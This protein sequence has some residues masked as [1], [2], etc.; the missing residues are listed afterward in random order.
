MTYVPSKSASGQSIVKSDGTLNGTPWYETA[1]GAGSNHTKTGPGILIGTSGTISSIVIDSATKGGTDGAGAGG[2]SPNS[3]I[4]AGGGQLWCMPY[5]STLAVNGTGYSWGMTT[6]STLSGFTTISRPIKVGTFSQSIGWP[7]SGL[8][9]TTITI[10]GPGVLRTVECN[11][12]RSNNQNASKLYYG[13]YDIK[14]NSAQT[15]N[16]DKLLGGWGFSVGSS[17]SPGVYAQCSL[18]LPFNG[19]L[20]LRVYVYTEWENAQP[21]TNFQY[22]YHN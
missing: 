7:N 6:A 3:S 5:N 14:V 9:E 22:T 20:K 2:T 16:V 13:G 11:I 4:A 8:R 1:N 21:T 18:F 12:T 15:S 10:T 17:D 19:T